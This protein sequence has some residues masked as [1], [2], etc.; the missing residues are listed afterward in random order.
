MKYIATFFK[1]SITLLKYTFLCIVT[2]SL[3]I[4]PANALSD[5]LLDFFNLNG[6]YYYN[7]SGSGFNG[8]YDG[9]ILIADG[10]AAEKI[11]SGLTSFL[12]PEQAA[13]VMGNMAHEG[14]Y[15]NPLQHEVSQ[16]NKYWG[17]KDILT[18]SS[19]PYGIGLIQ[20][21]WG[22]RVKMLQYVQD[23]APELLDYFLHPE[24][25][26][27]GYSI[28]GNKLMEIVGEDVYDSLIKVELEYLQKEL[29]DNPNGYGKL[30]DYNSVQSAADF[31]L[32]KVE[33]PSD[34]E[35]T[36]PG[37]RQDAQRY[38]DMF[39]GVILASSSSC[40]VLVSGGMN[41]DQ[42]YDF[43]KIYV[44]DPSECYTY[45]DM[46]DIYDIEPGGNCSTFSS[47]F[48][49]KYTTLGKVGLPNGRN[50]VNSLANNY[51][52]P[53]GS[54]P[55]PYAI[56]ST[57]S[58]STVCRDGQLCGHTGVVLGINEEAGEIYIGQM[59]YSHT[60]AWGLSVIR[61]SLDKYRNGSYTYAYTDEVLKSDFS[62]PS[63]DIIKY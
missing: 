22:R 56:F 9:N 55:R 3:V 10:T 52:L 17:K 59:G 61:S 32:E 7:P 35:S 50:V 30:L 43:M 47:Y 5:E 24:L 53:T 58:G 29:E 57:A 4:C 16:M 39:N 28:N 51:G 20:W 48:L 41:Y 2:T 31:F 6:I 45:S 37:R 63:D 25:Y 49:G 27:V 60:R 11:W 15:F 12:T 34:I 33:R 26:S 14:N 46:C 62:S 21:S 36:R 8:C 54:E 38:Y 18:D 13:G 42:A 23:H 1:R 19:I 44:D 40:G